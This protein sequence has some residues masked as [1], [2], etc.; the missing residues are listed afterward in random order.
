MRDCSLPL[1]VYSHTGVKKL[2]MVLAYAFLLARESID[3]RCS[4]VPTA[5]FGLVL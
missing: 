5:S 4:S 2:E 3:L 1:I